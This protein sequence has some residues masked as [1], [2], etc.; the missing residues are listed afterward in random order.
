MSDDTWRAVQGLGATLVASADRVERQLGRP[1]EGEEVDRLS[2][3]LDDL[4]VA[5]ARLRAILRY[6]GVKI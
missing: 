5:I 6:E 4:E 1:P 3:E 2:Q